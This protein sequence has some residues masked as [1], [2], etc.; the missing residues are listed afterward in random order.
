MA[1]ENGSNKRPAKT[2]LPTEQEPNQ[3]SKTCEEQTEDCCGCPQNSSTSSLVNT[4][5]NGINT[6]SSINRTE[7]S[8]HW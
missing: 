6:L 7:I 8:M 2:L 5:N 1:K 4:E 3:C